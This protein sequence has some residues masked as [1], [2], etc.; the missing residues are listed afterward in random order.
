MTGAN[1]RTVLMGVGAAGVTAVVAACGG[2]DT[3][4][5]GTS[6]SPPE[7]SPTEAPSPGGPLA[8]VTDVPVGGGLV[9]KEQKVVLTQPTAGEIKGFSGICTH[10]SCPLADVTGGTINCT[11]HGSKFAIADG[12]VKNGPAE[13]PLPEVKV[14]VEGDQVVRA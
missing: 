10:R 14:K 11:C 2:D 8:K 7:A 12:S 1:R 9:L 5:P 13:T 3:A 4:G 6:P